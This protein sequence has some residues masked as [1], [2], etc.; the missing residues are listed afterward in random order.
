MLSLEKLPVE[1]IDGL[2]T[3]VIPI[4]FLQRGWYVFLHDDAA[5]PRSDAPLLVD[6]DAEMTVWRYDCVLEQHPDG[7]L[8]LAFDPGHPNPILEL[9]VAPD[10]RIRW[11]LPGQEH[12]H[13]TWKMDGE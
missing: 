2:N 11:I 13:D 12:L 8:V 3:K 9:A 10:A 7:T 5:D 4:V 6:V 1:Q